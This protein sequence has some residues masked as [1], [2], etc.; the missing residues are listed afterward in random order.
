LVWTLTPAGK[1]SSKNAYTHCFNNLQLPPR[2][3]PK[4]V[5]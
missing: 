4:I 1:Y 3:R 5:P 2:Q